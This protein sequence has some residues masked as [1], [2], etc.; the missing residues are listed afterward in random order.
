MKDKTNWKMIAAIILAVQFLAG[1]ATVAVVLWLNLLPAVYVVLISVVLLWLLTVVY[2]F[3]YSGIS[4]KKRKQ[5]DRQ[6]KKQ[7]INIKRSAGCVL[8][9]FVMVLCV[10]VSSMLV[11][12]RK[13]VV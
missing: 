3:F 12:D 2:Y 4:K 9:A 1:T 7:M 5:M 13:S 10:V 11:Q 6:K 8:S